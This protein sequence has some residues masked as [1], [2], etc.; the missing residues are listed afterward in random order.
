[1]STIPEELTPDDMSSGATQLKTAEEKAREEAEARRL[2]ILQSSNER[3]GLV[4]GTV[5][6]PTK[7]YESND[8]DDQDTNNEATNFDNE[9]ATES[10]TTAPTTKP[11]SAAARMAAMRKMRFKKATGTADSNKTKEAVVTTTTET[12]SGSKDSA[13]AVAELSERSPD[14][15]NQSASIEVAEKDED[16]TDVTTT[17][18]LKEQQP[19][20]DMI[21]ATKKYEGVAK[22]RRRMIKNKQMQQQQG[23]SEASD[24]NEPLA[25]KKSKEKALKAFQMKNKKLS[26]SS[27][28]MIPF[29]ASIFT[30][31]LL[32]LAGLDVGLHQG[33]IDYGIQNE[34]IKV[35]TEFAP[36]RLDER[37]QRGVQYYANKYYYKT[38]EKGVIGKDNDLYAK[39][40]RDGLHDEFADSD[41]NIEVGKRQL[42]DEENIDPLF[43]VDLD[44][45]TAGTGLYFIVARFAVQCHRVN[46]AIFYYLP[47]RVI[48]TVTNAVYQLFVSPPLLCLVAI[49]VRQIIGKLILGAHNVPKVKS[50]M[51]D[52]SSATKKDQKDILGMIKN[53]A[54]QFITKSFPT[55]VFLYDVWTHIRS[56]MYVILLGFLIGVAYTHT[57]KESSVELGEKTKTS[58]GGTGTDEL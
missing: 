44:K 1:M 58:S 26:L 11:T 7:S 20:D 30:L 41:Y 16:P 14:F 52:E 53:I 29:Y 8:S 39:N 4:E 34:L 43:G 33:Q 3:M 49:T 46:L 37:F 51:E 42:Q 24:A 47:R 5:P 25:L 21:P 13:E 38:S 28:P 57:L 36:K 9:N 2:R 27:I 48:N 19:P 56:D 32:L 54:G 23:V 17:S 55:A 31:I 35:H 6:K 45:L 18:S 22:M 50:S 10:V 12:E 40:S 15:Q